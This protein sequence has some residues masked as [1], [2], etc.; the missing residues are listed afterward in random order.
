M[1]VNATGRKQLSSLMGSYDAYQD[2]SAVD[3]NFATVACEGAGAVEPIGTLLKWSAGD[4]AFLPLTVNA[5]WAALTAYVVG[6]VVKPATQDGYEYVCIAAGTSGASEPTFVTVSGA[7]TTDATVTW[8]ARE[9]YGI[10][11]SS[12]LPNQASVAISVGSLEGIGFN[13]ADVTLSG[14]AVNMTVLFRGAANILNEGIEWGAIAAADQAEIVAR[15][16]KQGI[17]VA[18]AAENVVPSYIV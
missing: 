12:P 17:S 8:M 5:D 14:T 16:E 7:P 15:L 13:K 10:D 11:V 1:P 4:S 18:D 2:E 6:D 9:P 3:Y